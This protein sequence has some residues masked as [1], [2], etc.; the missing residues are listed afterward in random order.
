MNIE[1]QL[2]LYLWALPPVHYKE[3]KMLQNCPADLP[4]LTRQ[5]DLSQLICPG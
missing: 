3:T 4:R 5:A 1:R 2:V